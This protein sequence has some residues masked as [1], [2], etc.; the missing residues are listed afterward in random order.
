MTPTI[1]SSYIMVPESLIHESVAEA[2]AFGKNGEVI[3]F[4]NIL[5]AG[6]QFKDAEMHPMY[7]F[8]QREFTIMVVAEETF[9]KLLH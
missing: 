2:E 5:M 7:L 8:D 3:N 1:S 9:G 6:Q 4:K